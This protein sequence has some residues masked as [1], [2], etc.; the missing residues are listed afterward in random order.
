MVSITYRTAHADW[1]AGKG[2]NL[3]AAEVDR[4]FHSLRLAVEQA[5]GTAGRGIASMTQSGYVLTVTYTDATSESFTLPAPD[6]EA[7]GAWAAGPS[8]ARGDLVSRLGGSYLCIASHVAVDWWTDLRAGRWATLAGT[9]TDSP[10][11]LEMATGKTLAWEIP[12]GLGFTEGMRLRVMSRAD[13]SRW[14]EGVVSAYAVQSGVWWL[15]VDVEAA[16][17]GGVL[18]DPILAPSAEGVLASGGG[19]GAWTAS[20]QVS[21]S[22]TVTPSDIGRKLTAQ[23]GSL[24]SLP[25]T[26]FQSGDAFWVEAPSDGTVTV[27]ATEG[28][29]EPPYVMM[30]FSSE[31]V[32]LVHQGGG[33]WLVANR[34]ELPGTPPRIS[35]WRYALA[36]PGDITVSL[37]DLGTLIV[38]EDGARVTLPGTYDGVQEGD[39]IWLAAGQDHRTR[40]TVHAP[41]GVDYTG[42]GDISLDGQIAQFVSL[43]YGRW[44]IASARRLNMARDCPIEW[45]ATIDVASGATHALAVLEAGHRFRL[46]VGATLAL[47]AVEEAPDGAVVWVQGESGAQVTGLFVDGGTRRSLSGRWARLI[48]DHAG[49]AWFLAEDRPNR[50]GSLPALNAETLAATPTGSLAD[51][52]ANLSTGDSYSDA[53]V[54]AAVN[55]ALSIH[56]KNVAELAGQMEALR[57]VLHDHGLLSV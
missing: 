34:E 19:G 25:G 54:V 47:P 10:T 48:A 7:R 28:G 49:S 5:A 36:L 16:S 40:I 13:R 1:G 52:Q 35:P 29:L 55:E 8:Y 45:V 39:M 31:R 57:G 20:V 9:L 44:I 38:C 30:D 2:T 15:S 23:A 56:N 22:H 41:G 37:A 32:W 18:S 42:G 50:P 46:G 6:T 11:A 17:G 43:G 26:G 3:T 33:D 21:G 4:N 12:G 14:M 27:Q 51:A 53:A 24:I